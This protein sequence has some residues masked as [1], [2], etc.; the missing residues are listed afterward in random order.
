MI[1]IWGMNFVLLGDR[2]DQKSLGLDHIRLGRPILATISL[3]VLLGV[4]LLG[5]VRQVF[6]IDMGGGVSGQKMTKCD[7]GG[8][9]QRK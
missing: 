2:L 4:D 1:F 7:K 5:A 8:R 3:G 6:V 9:K